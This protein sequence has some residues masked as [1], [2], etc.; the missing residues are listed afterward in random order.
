TTRWRVGSGGPQAV[1][2]PHAMSTRRPC[3]Q[4]AWSLLQRE[5]LATITVFLRARNC[6]TRRAGRGVSLTTLT[7]HVLLTRRP[8]CKKAWSLLQG[9]WTTLSTVW[10]ARN[11][12]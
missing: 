4:T 1:S 7:P 3:C 11:L 12:L 6:T 2:T 8:C 5:V 9:D 10:R